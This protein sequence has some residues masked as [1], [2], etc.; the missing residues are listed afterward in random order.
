MGLTATTKAPAGCAIKTLQRH[1]FIA[2]PA[3]QS[4]AEKKC[5]LPRQP[6]F[7]GQKFNLAVP[8]NKGLEYRIH[9]FGW[10]DKKKYLN[11]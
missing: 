1:D 11:G 3:G 4:S 8:F 10:E 2:H 6:V 7:W 9:C 5:R